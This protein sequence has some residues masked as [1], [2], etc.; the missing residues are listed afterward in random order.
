MGSARIQ[1]IEVREFCNPTLLH[2]TRCWAF[3]WAH[4]ARCSV[5]GHF[6]RVLISCEKPQLASSVYMSSRISSAPSRRI[7]VKFDIREFY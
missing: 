5:S 2:V 6:W 7:L 4:E 3:H 1:K